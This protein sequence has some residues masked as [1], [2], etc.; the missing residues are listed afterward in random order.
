MASLAI[1]ITIVSVTELLRFHKYR[2]NP[3]YPPRCLPHEFYH[4]DYYESSQPTTGTYSYEGFFT[5]QPQHPHGHYG[6]CAQQFGAYYCR[7][8][9]PTELPL[10]AKP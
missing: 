4:Q 9:D 5:P 8:S 2:Y 1:A 6:Q 10:I 7:I 3:N